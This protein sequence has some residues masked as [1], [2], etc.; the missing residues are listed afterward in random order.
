MTVATLRLSSETALTIPADVLVLGVAA[1]ESGPI[2]QSDDTALEPIGAALGA[3][4]ITGA[5]D[6]V[7]R[8]AA[9]SGSAKS[10]ALVGLGSAPVTPNTLRRA[11]GSAVRQ[12]TGVGTL[13]LA[14]PTAS[15]EDVYAVL[16]GA[17]I[18]SYS[19]T[20]YRS[21]PEELAKVPASDITVV[22]SATAT[23][24]GESSDD[25]LSRVNIV[26]GALHAEV[27][28]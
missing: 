22:T 24:T 15:N 28:S 6:E 18:A 13:S 10:I 2:L 23:T 26:A 8:L 7:R 3:L 11:A 20:R 4:G 25:V 14:L 17:A 9:P 12:L 5:E 16:E 19:Y 27:G 21:K 1:S